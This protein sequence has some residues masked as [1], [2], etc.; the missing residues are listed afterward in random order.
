MTKDKVKTLVIPYS[1]WYEEHHMTR[2]DIQYMAEK[3]FK[4]NAITHQIRFIFDY[5][6]EI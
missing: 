6:K 5:L 2:E 3:C 1:Y 4:D